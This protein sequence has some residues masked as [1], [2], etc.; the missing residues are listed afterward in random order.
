MCYQCRGISTYVGLCDTPSRNPHNEAPG[1]RENEKVL[2]P[3]GLF[4]TKKIYTFTPFLH[5]FVQAL[6]HTKSERTVFEMI[7][8]QRFAPLALVFL[9]EDFYLE[10]A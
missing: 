1:L 6:M 10:V 8:G 9:L 5:H 7:K 3:Q 2:E 4:G